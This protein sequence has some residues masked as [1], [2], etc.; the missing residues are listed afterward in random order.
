MKKNELALIHYECNTSILPILNLSG[1]KK[2]SKSI[3]QL[4]NKLH[5]ATTKDITSTNLE[6]DGDSMQ[7]TT[8][9]LQP[10]QLQQLLKHKTC[11]YHLSSQ[12]IL[13]GPSYLVGS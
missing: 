2:F 8:L 7:A 13:L 6:L 12:S 5:H 10:E 11:Q 3:I 1:K 4:L 9:P